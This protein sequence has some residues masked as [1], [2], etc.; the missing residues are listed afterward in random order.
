MSVGAIFRI[1]EPKRAHLFS[2]ASTML[3]G[4]V[5]TLGLTHKALNGN[6]KARTDCQ[7]RHSP[8]PFDRA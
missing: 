5:L 2:R 8:R 4:L 7:S 6:I 1:V 3:L